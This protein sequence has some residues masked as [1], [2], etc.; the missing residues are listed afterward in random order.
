MCCVKHIKDKENYLYPVLP[1]K[2][3]GKY[4]ATKGLM[5]SEDYGRL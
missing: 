5:T 4:Y 1:V 3:N 2:V